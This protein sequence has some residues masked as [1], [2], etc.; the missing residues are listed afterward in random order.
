MYET[1]VIVPFVKYLF[2]LLCILLFI[3]KYRFITGGYSYTAMNRMVCNSSRWKAPQQIKRLNHKKKIVQNMIPVMVFLMFHFDKILYIYMDCKYMKY[4]L[5]VLRVPNS[6]P[7][8]LSA[9]NSQ[10]LSIPYGSYSLIQ[11]FNYLE[12]K[13]IHCSVLNCDIVQSCR[14]LIALRWNWVLPFAVSLKT[15]AEVS[16]E[17]W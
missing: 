3:L 8:P 10:Q 5:P 12:G 1:F 2:Y 11:T 16:S 13:N 15:Q 6:H 17:T 7:D 14:R 9:L 4:K